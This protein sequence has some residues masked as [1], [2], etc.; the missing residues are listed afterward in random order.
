M[1]LKDYKKTLVA[2]GITAILLPVLFLARPKKAEA[3]VPVLDAAVAKSTAATAVSTGSL[4]TKEFA[5][6]TVAYTIAKTILRALTQSVVSWIQSGFEGQPGFISNFEDFLKDAGD[7]ATNQFLKEFLNPEVYNSICSPFRSQL[8]IA[9]QGA[10][11]YGGYGQQMSCTL[12]SAIQNTTDFSNS[13]R[14]GGENGWKN[15]L[16]VSLNPQNDPHMALLMTLDELSSRK[17]AA[18]GNAQTESIFNQGFLGLKK[19]AEYYDNQ[20]TGEFKCTKYETISPGKWVSDTLSEA[21]GIDF[22]QLALA[23]EINEIIAALIN[24]LL[25]GILQK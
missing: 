1:F 23:D 2:I 7:Q 18:Q 17:T 12:S 3:V 4:V 16:S 21:T 22:Q 9:I 6:D 24:Q 10:Q 8:R 5:L 14:E 11:Y 13:L 20:W 25:T 15:W 19:C